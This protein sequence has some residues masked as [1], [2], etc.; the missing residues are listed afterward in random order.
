[1]ST[2]EQQRL[3]SNLI[4]QSAHCSLINTEHCNESIEVIAEMQCCASTVTHYFYSET[5]A[6]LLATAIS[7]QKSDVEFNPQP[8]LGS[9]ST[10]YR[11]P[12]V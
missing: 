11:P 10:R 3:L 6:L 5:L 9:Q 8:L 2:L 12:I 1:M 7:Q 4:E